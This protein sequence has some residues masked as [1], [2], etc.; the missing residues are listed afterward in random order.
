ILRPTDERRP[1]K[2]AR[3]TQEWFDRGIHEYDRLLGWVFDHQPLT[4]LVALG[5][6]VLTVVLYV[7][8][9]K[10]F[11]P[12]QDTGV[13]QRITEAAPTVSSGA[14]QEG[15]QTLADTILGGRGVDSSTPL[16]AVDGPNTTLTSGRSLTKLKPKSEGN[17]S[18]S[19]TGGRLRR[20]SRRAT[21]V[22]LFLQ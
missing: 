7:V 4:L 11:F 16:T 3:V 21:G 22:S 15:K 19:Q 8:I 18:I 2:I 9:P 13:I 5:T 14:M 20:A 6:L 1:G 10:G 17:D 12:V